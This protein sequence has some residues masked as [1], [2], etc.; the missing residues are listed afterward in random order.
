MTSNVKPYT[1]KRILA[2][3]VG[4]FLVVFL[5]NGIMTYF[6]LSTWTGLET[7]NAYV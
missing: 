3:F 7:E 4:F 5:A 2:W 6:A 1:G